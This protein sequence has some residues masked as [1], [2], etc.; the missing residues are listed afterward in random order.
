ML[1][2]LIETIGTKRCHESPTDESASIRPVFRSSPGI[3]DVPSR[4]ANP[5]VPDVC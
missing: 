4:V 5:T 3:D 1:L 2:R